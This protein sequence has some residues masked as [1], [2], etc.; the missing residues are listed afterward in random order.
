[1]E[2]R[3]YEVMAAVEDR[4][5]WFVGTRGIVA[6]ACAAAG[7]GPGSTVLD[8]GCG[9]GGTMRAVSC[10]GRF[11]GVDMNPTAVRL[12]RRRTGNLV[13]LADCRAL[14]FADGSFD[15][16]LAL[17]TFEHITD[18]VCAMGEVCRVLRPGC[19]LVTTVPCHPVLYA[20]HDRAL[21]HVRRYTRKEFLCRVREAGF[22]VE[23]TTWINALLFPPA[24]VFRLASRLLTR[25][26]D[27]ANSDAG[28]ALGP[29]NGFLTRV[30]QAER[31]ILRRVDLPFGLGLLI[32]AR[33]P[34]ERTGRVH[35]DW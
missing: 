24:A 3:E 9:T 1:M 35:Q 10:I 30:F 27:P 26:E 11:V 7:L 5:F 21:H 23:R 2:E 14:P 33:R 34:G 13:M 25:A 18:D 4:H 16:V 6:D 31:A 8:V 12:A 17:D 15:G 19:V 22:E 20:E 32:V 29:L 28:M